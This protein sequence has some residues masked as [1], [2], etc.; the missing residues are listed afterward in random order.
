M[1]ERMGGFMIT[2]AWVTGLAILTLFF[3]SW[4]DREDNPNRQVD[5]VI[6][7]DGAREVVLQRNRAGHYVAGGSINGQEVTFLLDTGATDVALSE[8][9][10]QRVG[11]R[12][13]G[14]ALSRTA[15]GVVQS[16]T[17]TLDSVSLG[18]LALRDV[19]ATVLPNMHGT[20]ALLGMSYLK[21]LQ[22][23]QSG[24]KLILRA[25]GQSEE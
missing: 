8:D 16:W 15:N 4:L 1:P 19:R 3:G 21:H 9:L 22:M 13:Q 17:T 10:A 25:P 18:G 2:A 6:A 7:A 20:D 5:A 11:A 12:R 14:T 23:I 24:D